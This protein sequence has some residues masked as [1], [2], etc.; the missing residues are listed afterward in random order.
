MLLT[1]SNVKIMKGEKFGYRTFGIHF[2]P[3]KLS[4]KNVC[5]NASKGCAASCLN[6]S[7]QGYYQRVQDAR[8]K[9]TKYFFNDREKFLSEL[10]ENITTMARRS[11]KNS[12]VPC[13]RL[14][15]TSDIAWESIKINGKNLM[16]LFP[17]VQFYD[18]CKNP[19]R[20]LNFLGGK[21]PKNYHLTFSRSESNQTH[22]DIVMGCGGNVAMVFRNTLPK[23]YKGKRVIDGDESD[24]RF[25]DPKDVIVGLVAKGVGR[26]DESGFIIDLE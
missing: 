25:L 16:E 15:L 24:L 22:C 1:T 9:K 6:I 8:V 23:T 21:F 18:Y 13:F 26:K 10:L 12:M 4:G 14:N 19:K 3:A 20:M 5:P 17:D 7:G 2:A 11:K